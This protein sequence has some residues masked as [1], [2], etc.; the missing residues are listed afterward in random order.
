M[1]CRLIGEQLNGFRIWTMFTFAFYIEKPPFEVRIH[2]VG[3]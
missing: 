1:S 2:K 3:Y